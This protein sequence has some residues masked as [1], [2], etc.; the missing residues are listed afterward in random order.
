MVQSSKIETKVQLRASTEISVR[1]N[2]PVDAMGKEDTRRMADKVG[3]RNRRSHFILGL[4]SKKELFPFQFVEGDGPHLRIAPAC[5]ELH[6]QAKCKKEEK[7]ELWHP[8]LASTAGSFHRHESSNALVFP[9]RELM[10][11]DEYGRREQV[12]GR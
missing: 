2:E 6:R 9:L 1:P 11:Q 4:P 8:R 10:R 5:W 7:R 12:E 3:Q